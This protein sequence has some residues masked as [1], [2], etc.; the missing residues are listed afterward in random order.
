MVSKSTFCMML[1]DHTPASQLSLS[2]VAVIGDF[3]EDQGWMQ[4]DQNAE[5]VIEPVSEN[6]QLE[7]ADDPEP[8]PWEE[9]ENAE[10]S[11][12]VPRGRRPKAKAKPKHGRGH[13]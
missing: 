9:D 2:A 12:T 8:P 7:G 4:F 13:R 11:V 6:A 3:I 1:R 10:E 5:T